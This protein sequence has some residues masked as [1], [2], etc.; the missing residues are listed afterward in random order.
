MSFRKRTFVSVNN[1]NR[2]GANDLVTAMRSAAIEMVRP[3]PASLR[4][5]CQS[6]CYGLKSFRN[7]DGARQ[8]IDA[9]AAIT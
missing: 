8:D 7:V 5:I 9:A 1:D 6:A 3:W 4:L 2:F